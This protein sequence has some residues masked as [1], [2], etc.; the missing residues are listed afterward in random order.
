MFAIRARRPIVGGL[1]LLTLGLLSAAPILAHGHRHVNGYEFTVG[2]MNEPVFTGQKSG[3]EFGVTDEA[4]QPV[5]GLEETLQAEV[6]YAGQTRA[7]PLEPAFGQDGWYES[8]F[9][10]TAAGSYTFR[11]YGTLNGQQIDESFT[12]IE[13]DFSEVQEQTAGQFP[14]ILPPAGDVAADAERGS[15]AA[16][17][18][19]IALALGVVGIVLG[20]IALGLA[21]AGRRRT[22]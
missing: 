7:L 17:M 6:I 13:D 14:T 2:F 21:L 1:L 3:L 15:S 19:P 9:F 20:M 11:I 18:M 5:M 12:S 16:D 10:P 22:A 4:D 8:V